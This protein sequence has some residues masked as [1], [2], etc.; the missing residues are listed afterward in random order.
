MSSAEYHEYPKHVPVAAPPGY[1]QVN[2]EEEERQA[3]E[4][5]TIVRDEDER[6][7]MMAV[8]SLY[9]LKI[10]RRWGLERMAKAIREAGYDPGLDPAK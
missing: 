4:Q 9:D 1:V 8:A 6:A 3:L 7:R 10:D 2:N 5:G